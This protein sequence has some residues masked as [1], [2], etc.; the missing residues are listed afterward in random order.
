MATS[1]GKWSAGI[2]GLPFS[3]LHQTA[4]G[5]LPGS[6]PPSFSVATPCFLSALSSRMWQCRH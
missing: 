3:F 4:W 2:E 6:W 5:I 1:R